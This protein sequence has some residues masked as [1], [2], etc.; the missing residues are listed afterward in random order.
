MFIREAL[1]QSIDIAI[2]SYNPDNWGVFG[3]YLMHDE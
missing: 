3:K 1:K 2:H